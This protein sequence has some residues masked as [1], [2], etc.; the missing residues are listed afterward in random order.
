MKKLSYENSNVTL[1]ET[2]TKAPENGWDWKTMYFPFGM[3]TSQGLLLLNFRWVSWL[4][5]SQ[6]KME[7]LFNPRKL[8]D[9]FLRTTC[10]KISFVFRQINQFWMWTN[11]QGGVCSTILIH[12]VKWDPYKWPEMNEQLGLSHP[13]S[14][15]IS[16][17]FSP[18]TLST[19]ILVDTPRRQWSKGAPVQ[20]HEIWYQPKQCTIKEK[21][22]NS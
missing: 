14:G 9:L 2:N 15:V 19:S 11:I 12:G 3:V 17:Y 8:V 20:S 1:P 18:C 22:P 10:Q 4:A 21:D 5:T 16:H 6:E 7:H 13:I